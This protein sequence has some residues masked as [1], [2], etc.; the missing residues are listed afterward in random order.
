[1]ERPEPLLATLML[2]PRAVEVGVELLGDAEGAAPLDA[3]VAGPEAWS[4]TGGGPPGS[5]PPEQPATR[6]AEQPMAAT[7]SRMARR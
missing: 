2:V 5:C 4:A 1:L 3:A 6:M 7:S